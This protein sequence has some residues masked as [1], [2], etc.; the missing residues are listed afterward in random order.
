MVTLGYPGPGRALLTVQA[1]LGCCL[2][3]L[4]ITTQLLKFSVCVGKEVCVFS[5]MSTATE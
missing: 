3:M 5:S 1:L 4:P 2:Q